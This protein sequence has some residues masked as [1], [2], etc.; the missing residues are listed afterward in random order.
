M[1]PNHSFLGDAVTANS[2]I[3]VTKNDEFISAGNSGDDGIQVFIKLVLDLIWVGHGGC[4]GTGNGDKLLPIGK[5][6]SHHHEP[7]FHSFWG[8]QPTCQQALTSQQS[9]LQPHIFL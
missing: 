7:I 5:V 4:I 8:G 6:E 1:L 3:K 2:C 9:Q